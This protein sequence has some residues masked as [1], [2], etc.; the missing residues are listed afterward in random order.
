MWVDL[1]ERNEE[2]F[3]FLDLMPQLLLLLLHKLILICSISFFFFYFLLAR[4]V[5]CCQSTAGIKS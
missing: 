1:Y 5:T 4:C 3:I 2:C